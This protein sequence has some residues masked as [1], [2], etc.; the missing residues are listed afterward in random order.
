MRLFPVAIFLC[1]SLVAAGALRQPAPG[2]A[3]GAPESRPELAA[4]TADAIDQIRG[5]ALQVALAPDVT[6]RRFLDNTGGADALAR[7]L[8]TAQQRGGTRW[9]GANICEVR[10]EISGAEVA[11][12]VRELPAPPPRQSRGGP[13][14]P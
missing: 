1:L 13:P 4:A 11:G 6:V 12:E 2:D 14:G 7:R 3:D 9:R 10:M 8:E 5:D